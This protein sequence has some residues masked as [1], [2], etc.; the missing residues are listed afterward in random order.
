MRS[1]RITAHP[2]VTQIW[3][4]TELEKSHRQT[5]RVDGKLGTGAV[6]FRGKQKLGSSSVSRQDAIL[7][8]R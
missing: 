4:E 3:C 2:E 1:G 8:L 6:L 5:N 7:L